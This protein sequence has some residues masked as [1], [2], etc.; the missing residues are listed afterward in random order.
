MN[1]FHSETLHTVIFVVKT[2]ESSLLNTDAT[3]SQKYWYP[4]IRDTDAGYMIQGFSNPAK[5]QQYTTLFLQPF[6]L[7]HFPFFKPFSHKCWEALHHCVNGTAILPQSALCN[8]HLL[9]IGK[10]FGH[11]SVDGCSWHLCFWVYCLTKYWYV[12]VHDRI[13]WLTS[14]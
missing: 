13:W 14:C 8:V 4:K 6:F 9:I 1:N 2:V 7:C 3:S 12:K 10:H 5:H 11:S